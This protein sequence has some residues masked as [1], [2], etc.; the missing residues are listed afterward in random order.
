MIIVNVVPQS[1]ELVDFNIKDNSAEFNIHFN[2][3]TDR[4]LSMARVIDDS[5]TIAEQLVAEIRLLSKKNN[6]GLTDDWDEIIVVRMEKEDETIRK[7]TGFF[8]RVKERIKDIRGMRT[9]NGFLDK[10]HK[11]KQLVVEF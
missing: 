1:I 7:M 2:D 10:V 5:E 6:K 8:E 4:R 9:A 3:G 11:S